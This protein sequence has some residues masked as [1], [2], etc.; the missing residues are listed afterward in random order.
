MKIDRFNRKYNYP[1]TFINDVPF[2][3]EFKKRTSALASGPCTYGLIPDSEWSD[4]GAWI[5]QDQASAAR[6]AMVAKDV[7][8]GG[9]VSYRQMCRYQSGFFW[10]HPLLDGF[11]YYWRI[12]YVS[13]LLLSTVVSSST[14]ADSVMPNLLLLRPSVKYFCD[15]D[16]DPFLLMQDT[17][18]K[19]GFTVT[20]YEYAETIVTLWDETKSES[21]SS[22]FSPY[23]ANVS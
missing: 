7:I 17:G 5:D 20:I 3:D 12:E 23:V 4:Q 9:S 18:K 6:D 19:Y 1:Y 11:K 8:Y 16:Y 13:L 14:D 21:C 15:L 10:R 2:T 22:P